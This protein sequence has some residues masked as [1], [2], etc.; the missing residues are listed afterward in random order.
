MVSEQIEKRGINNKKI[1]SAMLD[2]PRH[3]FVNEAQREY[4][5]ND[6]PLSIGEGQT[7]SQ[8][9]I[10]ALMTSLLELKGDE[11]ILEIGTGSGYQAAILAKLAETVYSIEKIEVLA[12]RAMSVLMMLNIKNVHIMVGNG[13]IGVQGGSFDRIIVTAASPD[14]PEPLIEQLK[15]DGIMVIPVGE[16]YSQML[17]VVKKKHGEITKEEKGGCIFVPLIGKYGFDSQFN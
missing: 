13:S 14:L 11:I 6:Y 7:I 8:P 4:A 5:Y 3:L 12:K 10:V 16:K 9:Y 2:I 15:D 17:I 1:L